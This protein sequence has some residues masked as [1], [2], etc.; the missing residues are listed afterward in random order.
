[1]FRLTALSKSALCQTDKGTRMSG[2]AT[3]GGLALLLPVT[4][5]NRPGRGPRTGR[6]AR[7]AL[8]REQPDCARSAATSSA[9][10][11]A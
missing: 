6:S 7:Y 1:M 9:P 8:A 5:L 3:N 2:A 4:V 10:E 11:G